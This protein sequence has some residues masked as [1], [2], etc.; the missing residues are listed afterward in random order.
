MAVIVQKTVYI[1]YHNH[2]HHIHPK[3]WNRPEKTVDPDQM[4]LY[5]MSAQG[6]HYLLLIQGPVIQ[7]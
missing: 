6:L 2:D 5:T 7:S 4:L 3:Y 1:V